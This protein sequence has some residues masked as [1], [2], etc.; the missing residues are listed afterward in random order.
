M[1]KCYYF[2]LPMV[3]ISFCLLM[4]LSTIQEIP[5]KVIIVRTINV[6]I[7]FGPN[8]LV[9]KDKNYCLI[10]IISFLN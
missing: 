3:L 4:S 5:R 9:Y 10:I 7:Q 2:H 8:Q 1:K 6:N